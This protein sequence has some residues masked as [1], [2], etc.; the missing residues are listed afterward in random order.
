MRPETARTAL[1]RYMEW[2]SEERWCAGWRH[3]L[4][5]VLW[6]E[7]VAG[8]DDVLR[9]LAAGAGGWWAWDDAADQGRRFLPARE[10]E[11][12]HEAWRAGKRTEQRT[13]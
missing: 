11:R 9:E 10:W 4:E 2:T 13:P 12:V 5:H 1:L 8:Q 6:D 7:V 3:D